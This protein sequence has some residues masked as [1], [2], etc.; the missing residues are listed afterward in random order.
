[1][2]YTYNECIKKYGSDYQLK[3]ALLDQKLYK[4]KKASTHQRNMLLTLMLYH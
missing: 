4:V 3:K 1:M 2:L